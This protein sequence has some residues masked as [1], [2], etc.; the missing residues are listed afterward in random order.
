MYSLLILFA[1]IIF[2]CIFLNNASSRLG[3][4]V[5]FA[6]ILL[7][8]IFGNSGLMSITDD[9]ASF[10]GDLC[11]VALVFIMFY[12]GFGTS[13]TKAR[14][15]SLE[16]GL[17]STLGVVLTAGIVGLFCHYFPRT[18]STSFLISTQNS[19]LFSPWL[20]K[21]PPFSL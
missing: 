3:I 8:I 16:A 15:V 14:A 13:W 21:S 20:N 1:V 18:Q 4:P 17:L 19:F 7:G 10:V 12:G 5:L 2:A 11:S 9:D 6:F